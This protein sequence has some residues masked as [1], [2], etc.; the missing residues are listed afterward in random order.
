MRVS[1]K[2]ESVKRLIDPPQ[3]QILE[4]Q[5]SF[6]TLLTIMM[7]PVVINVQS[8][9]NL[10]RIRRIATDTGTIWERSRVTHYTGIAHKRG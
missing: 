5:S 8:S 10:L 2:E 9:N 4:T 3:V 1:G 6:P 7:W